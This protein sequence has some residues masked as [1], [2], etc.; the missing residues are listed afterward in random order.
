MAA[1]F[2]VSFLHD[3]TSVAVKKRS[4]VINAFFVAAERLECQN[5]L[6]YPILN[7]KLKFLLGRGILYEMI[8]F[9][10]SVLNCVNVIW[11]KQFVQ[12]VEK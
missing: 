2:T 10:L 4:A 6:T 9:S 5:L 7:S 3:M 8:L 1:I 12:L 11:Q